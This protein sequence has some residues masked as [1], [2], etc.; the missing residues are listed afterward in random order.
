MKI[1]LKLPELRVHRI[2]RDLVVML[3]ASLAAA[4][5]LVTAGFALL[6]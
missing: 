2:Y 3:L 6:Q 5:V 1:S 4:A